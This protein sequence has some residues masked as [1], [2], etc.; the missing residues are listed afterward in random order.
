LE[1]NFKSLPE[2]E[3]YLESSLDFFSWNEIYS[4]ERQNYK[5]LISSKSVLRFESKFSMS[6]DSVTG[7][8]TLLID[9][10]LVPLERFKTNAFYL[11]L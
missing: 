2:E 7:D 8:Y 11:L 10:F 9:L 4:R 5:L 1:Q 3:I 6:S